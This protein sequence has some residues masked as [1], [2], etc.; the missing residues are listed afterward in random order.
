MKKIIISVSIVVLLLSVGCEKKQ[1]CSDIMID[2]HRW[3]KEK[4]L[5]YASYINNNISQS[6]YQKRKNDANEAIDELYKELEDCE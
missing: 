4:E 3:E 1:S 5:S 2:I 6:T